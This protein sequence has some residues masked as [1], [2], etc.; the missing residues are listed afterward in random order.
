MG[1]TRRPETLNL[2]HIVRFAQA[3]AAALWF[4]SCLPAM[5]AAASTADVDAVD[6]PVL[7][8]PPQITGP[9]DLAWTNAAKL[10]LPTNFTARRAA[11]EPTE[12]YVGQD[13]ANLDVAFVVTQREPV[14]SAQETN[15]SSV[16]SD[17]YVMVYLWPQGTQ[18]FAYSF[19][20]NPRGARY[21]TSSEN[22]AY[23]PT[24]NSFGRTTPTGYT[25][26]MQIPLSAIRS[27]GSKNWRAQ[28]ARA[29]VASNGLSVWTF[30]DREQNAND[31]AFAGTLRDV[32][33]AAGSS[34]RP[35]PRAGFYML[36]ESTTQA[37]GGSTSRVG[38]DFSLPVTPTASLVGTLH[39]DYS[40]VEIDQ[41]TIAPNAFAYQYQE[42]RPFFTQ[43]GQGFN[44]NFSCS[45]CPQLLYTPNIPTFA[46]GYALE[47]TQGR[48]TFSGFDAI[49]ND[50]TDQAL[51][52]DYNVETK[53]N[54]YGIN[55]QRVGVDM[56]GLH[57]D[58]TSITTGIN[59]QHTHFFL[60]GN[61][62]I[63]RGT[64]VTN[65]PL[66]NYLEAG[67]GYASA[68]TV[69]VANYQTIGAQFNPV[70]SFVSQTDITG[71]E[72]YARHMWDFSP[73]ALLHDV[74]A[75]TFYAWYHDRFGQPAQVDAS[76][77]VFLDFRNLMTLRLFSNYFGAKVLN[78]E[79][80]PFDGNS[81]ELGYKLATNTPS[82]VQY[83]GGPYYH[84]QLDAWS[85]VSTVPIHR[86]LRLRLEADEN[87]YL[88]TY[89]GE[90]GDAQW[91][92]RATLDYQINR[93]AAFDVGVRRIIGPN[94][95]NAYSV[96]DFTPVNAGN[97][98]VAFHILSA[99]NEFYLVYG[100]ANSLSTL[101]AFY[102]KWIRY[103][104]APK[105][106]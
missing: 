82:Y 93:D 97:V 12:V 33:V 98:T 90:I 63:D 62:A 34:L 45:D 83:S 52:L 51:A 73:K 74:Q 77:N 6:V 72:F 95:P 104:G 19:A 54:A 59:N 76:A 94:L 60:Y 37:N 36:G 101:P 2:P 80:L 64:N 53:D 40:N 47:G 84:G 35:R 25:V 15:G 29:C 49:A 75:Q 61:A 50:R 86:K 99:K 106:T 27:G 17:D 9:I 55:V 38:A 21:Q 28:F 43:A 31:P 85:Y 13:N 91:L 23:T 89:P 14:L 79:F 100:N 81:V 7:K 24:W 78:G 67:G 105:G 5:A 3:L 22:S 1:W 103:V 65:A 4:S 102:V 30:S 87:K 69:V 92:E 18:G 66:G 71:Y 32:G 11:D 68:K 58:L 44:Y 48:L 16:T 42:V 96:P 20:A 70:D 26:T 10:T 8:P 88:T 39:P 56:T 57:D 41:Q 46:Q